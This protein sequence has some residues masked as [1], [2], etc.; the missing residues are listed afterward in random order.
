[1]I[2]YLESAKKKAKGYYENL[3]VD[4]LLEQARKGVK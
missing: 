2:A 4:Y 1:V 3:L